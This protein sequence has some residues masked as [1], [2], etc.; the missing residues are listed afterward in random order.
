MKGI[1][2]EHGGLALTRAENKKGSSWAEERHS[3]QGDLTPVRSGA[4]D[5]TSSGK[6]PV[7]VT[8]MSPSSVEQIPEELHEK[9]KAEIEGGEEHDAIE[10]EREL[11]YSAAAD[12]LQSPTELEQALYNIPQFV[13][14]GENRK[15]M[16]QHM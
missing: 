14:G 6:L 5:R 4:G 11:R 8:L 2:D 10:A 9:K 1:P 7:K 16:R 13:R 12:P 15:I 3:L